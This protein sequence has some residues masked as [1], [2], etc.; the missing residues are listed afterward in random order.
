[1]IRKYGLVNPPSGIQGEIGPTGHTGATGNTEEL[2]NKI[3]LLEDRLN[4]LERKF[5]NQ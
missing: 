1:M 3:K 4:E 5:I 2:E